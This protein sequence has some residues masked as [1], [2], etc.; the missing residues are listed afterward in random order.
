MSTIQNNSPLSYKPFENSIKSSSIHYRSILIG[1]VLGGVLLKL[2]LLFLFY[3]HNVK[4]LMQPDSGTYLIPA[5]YL[6]KTGHYLLAPHIYMFF[7]TPAYPTFIA[8]IFFIFGD[9]L[10]A[11]VIA[12]ILLS[13]VLVVCAY[14]IAAR[15]FSLKAGIYAA[16]IVALDY[17]LTGY[18]Y[19]VLTDMLFAVFI[20]LFF[21]MGVFFLTEKAPK[22]R[23]VFFMG[24]FLAL[25]T[26][27]RPI[28][29]FL[30]IPIAF[31]VLFFSITRRFRFK[32]TALILLLLFLPNVLLV[33]GWQLRN[34]MTVDT[35]QYSNI[36]GVGGFKIFFPKVYQSV[37]NKNQKLGIKQDVDILLHHPLLTIK[38]IMI[39]SLRVMFG[40]D[41]TLLRFFD[42]NQDMRVFRK[43]KHDLLQYQFK[44]AMTTFL[45]RHYSW[46]VLIY[47]A[48]ILWVNLLLYLCAGLALF[49]LRGQ[50]QISSLWI[51]H[52]FLI[53]SAA[54]FLLFSSNAAS[55]ARFRLPFQIII[56]CYAA[57]GA[58]FAL[59]KLKSLIRKD[60]A[61]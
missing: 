50:K 35:F 45:Q 4:Q 7:R 10:L 1:I 60:S 11:V 58:Y 53:G 20:G 61:A 29:Y 59:Q 43:I 55:Y 34:K 49:K 31:G 12:Q 40:T 56:D 15:L 46:F 57:A 38:Q 39:G 5:Q 23:Y 36:M 26:L 51:A 27:A 52:V 25:A 16:C 14:F 9:H 30:I 44:D 19:M 3:H 8:L 13:S 2:I 28:S 18:T 22:Y 24:F 47:I 37:Q 33:G 17:L 48:L 41:H 42:P 21:M 32:K 54:Y 6:L